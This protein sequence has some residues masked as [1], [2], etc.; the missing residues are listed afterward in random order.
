MRIEA[1]S[2]TQSYVVLILAVLV[3]TVA[4]FVSGQSLGGRTHL[5]VV[6]EDSQSPQVM[7][8]VEENLRP[9]A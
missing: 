4:G 7:V 1:L 9:V 8:K 5:I 2:S 6:Y 3:F